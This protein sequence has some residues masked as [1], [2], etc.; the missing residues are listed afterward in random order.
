MI[1]IF[2]SVSLFI[3]N[4]DNHK[5]DKNESNIYLYH[6][7]TKYNMCKTHC[8]HDCTDGLSHL[9]GQLKSQS[10]QR[11]NLVRTH[12]GLFVHCAEGLEWLK[13]Y[14]KGGEG[15]AVHVWLCGK[16]VGRVQGGESSWVD[17]V[18]L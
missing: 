5:I 17:G 8:S 11:E 14:R 9:K 2:S 3:Y 7:N 15:V 10:F 18:C 16:F 6:H 4:N 12:F 13:A 1:V